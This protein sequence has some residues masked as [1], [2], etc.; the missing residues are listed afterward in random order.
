RIH[1]EVADSEPGVEGAAERVIGVAGIGVGGRVAEVVA[2]DVV[3]AH[4]VADLVDDAGRGGADAAVDPD[5]GVDVRVEPRAAHDPR[6]GA[7]VDQADVVD[8]AGRAVAAPDL[9]HGLQHV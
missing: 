8:V 4:V 1:L 5:V 7:G 6:G 2:G 3:E 9:L